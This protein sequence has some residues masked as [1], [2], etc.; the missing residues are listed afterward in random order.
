MT[1]DAYY[2]IA[3][4]YASIAALTS[5]GL[6]VKRFKKHF[7]HPGFIE[8]VLHGLHV[9]PYLIA[10]Y[11]YWE[12]YENKYTNPASYITNGTFTNVSNASYFT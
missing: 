3:I 9:P 4:A 7:K 8:Y 11:W 6:I 5:V 12:G 2:Y 10:A 1:Q